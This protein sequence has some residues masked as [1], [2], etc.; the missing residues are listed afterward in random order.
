MSL[1]GSGSNRDYSSFWGWKWSTQRSGDGKSFRR[2]SSAWF[3]PWAP[4]G[5]LEGAA[6]VRVSVTLWFCLLQA[7]IQK[8]PQSQ[9]SWGPVR[10]WRECLS[11]SS[12]SGPGCGCS[13][14]L[15]S[16]GEQDLCRFIP[17]CRVLSAA[18]FS[19]G[20]PLRSLAPRESMPRSPLRTMGVAQC[21]NLLSCLWLWPPLRQ[22][23]DPVSGPLARVLGS[24]RSFW[25]LL[26]LLWSN[27]GCSGPSPVGKRWKGTTGKPP[28]HRAPFL[29]WCPSLTG[30][31]L[32][33]FAASGSRHL[34][35]S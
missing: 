3:R 21:F 7:Q 31:L 15:C 10:P 28:L 6:A 8:L 19:P 14:P 22:C 5:L 20:L 24:S 4:L 11:K 30:W 13:L 23:W 17:E 25:W 34:S 16:V 35:L 27:R 1:Y 32:V 18:L 33:P 12:S 26:C 9:L 2:K 29:S